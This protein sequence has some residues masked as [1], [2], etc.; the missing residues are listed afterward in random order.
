M[1]CVERHPKQRKSR[2]RKSYFSKWNKMELF[3]HK[4]EIKKKKQCTKVD[5]GQYSRV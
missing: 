1:R 4:V 5:G 3:E 2:R